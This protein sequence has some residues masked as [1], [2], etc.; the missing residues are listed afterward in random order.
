MEFSRQEYWSRLSFS[1]PRDL[2]DPGTEPWSPKL[3]QILYH[4]S[5]QG[6]PGRNTDGKQT[7]KYIHIIAS[8]KADRAGGGEA[9]WKLREDLSEDVI[10]K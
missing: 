7:N 2:P 1:S 10:F 3:Q 5:Y 9:F 8:G 6:S 4:L